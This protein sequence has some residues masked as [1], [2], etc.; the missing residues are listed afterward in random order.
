MYI[1]K[2]HIKDFRA[3]SNSEDDTIINLGKNITCIAGHNGIGKSTILAILSNCGELKVRDGKHLNGLPFR[4]EYSQ[5]IKGDERFDTTGKK[6]EIFFDDL[7]RIDNN[8][9]YLPELSFRATFQG[10]TSNKISYTQKEILFEDPETGLEYTEIYYKKIEEQIRKI[11]YR[12]LPIRTEQRPTEKKLNWPT[13]YLGLSRLFPVGETDEMVENTIDESVLTQV[14][15][16]HKSILSST[17]TPINGSHVQY[18]NDI[19]K[20]GFGIETE[21]YGG[22][23]NSSGQDN[24]GQ[25]LLTIFSFEKLKNTLGNSY[26]GGIFLIDEIDATLHPSAQNKLFD[27]LKTKSIEL[28]LQI[29]FTTHSLSLME[30]ITRMNQLT[31]HNP[32]IKL[33]YLTNSHAKIEVETNPTYLF[34][35]NDMLLT[36]SGVENN[37]TVPVMTEDKTARWFLNKILETSSE[38]FKFQMLEVSFGWEQILALIVNDFYYYRN[39]INILDP[40]LNLPENAKHVQAKLSGSRFKFKAETTKNTSLVLALPG[41]KPIE[42]LLW[43]YLESLEA[44]HTFYLDRR[45]TELQLTKRAVFSQ[46]PRENTNYTSV[47]YP[48]AIKRWADDNYI[49]LDI[50]F[51]FWAKENEVAIQIF[52]DDLKQEYNKIVSNKK[53]VS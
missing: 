46:G 19:N 51:D 31:E 45:S 16:I 8:N 23:A 15:D 47:P 35:K 53:S 32:T 20:S 9:P 41:D 26:N 3:F 12:L 18:S 33:I 30:H 39:Q 43:E 29:V 24:L 25:I 13:Y 42:Q 44:N 21:N 7:P 49:I 17:D 27:F 2:V 11:R 28:N 48:K 10:K 34:I 52:I 5:I 1:K 14:K 4:G 38:N 50:V 6:C 36:Y 40:E 37:I 22:L